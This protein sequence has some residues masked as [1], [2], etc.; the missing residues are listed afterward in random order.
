VTRFVDLT[1]TL[2]KL[3]LI[4]RIIDVAT[5]R[6]K[7]VCGISAVFKNGGDQGLSRSVN[8]RKGLAQS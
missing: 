6:W 5:R 2:L 1:P 4:P 8:R 7:N 3:L